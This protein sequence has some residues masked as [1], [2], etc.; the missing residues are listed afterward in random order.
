[1]AWDTQGVGQE[2]GVRLKSQAETV[3]GSN[4]PRE[5]GQWAS[6]LTREYVEKAKKTDRDFVGV[7]EERIGPVQNKLLSSRDVQGS[8]FGS[9]RK[10]SQAVYCREGL[11]WVLREVLERPPFMATNIET[12]GHP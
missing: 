12:P 9:F 10:A 8:I 1:M 7:E 11:G 2:D 5:R 4:I 6:Q 3:L